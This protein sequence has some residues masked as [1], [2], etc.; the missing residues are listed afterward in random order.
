MPQALPLQN[1]ISQAS[2]AEVE[3]NVLEVKYGNG[4]GQAVADGI[5]STVETWNLT[6]EQLS[7]SNYST[8]RTA[9]YTAKGIDYFTWQP[10]GGSS[11]LKFKIRKFG[12]MPQSGD[13]YSVSATLT[14]CFDL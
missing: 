9:F 3:F 10:I 14:Q 11:T 2:Q 12:M 13:L 5:N 7:L 8:L 6:W 4:Q 1:L